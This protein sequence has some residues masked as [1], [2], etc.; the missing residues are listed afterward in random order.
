M[1]SLD[2]LR[3]SKVGSTGFTIRGDRVEFINSPEGKA[4][5]TR[6]TNGRTPSSMFCFAL[7]KSKYKLI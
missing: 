1:N 3:W 6:G 4:V 2:D 5:G 7:P